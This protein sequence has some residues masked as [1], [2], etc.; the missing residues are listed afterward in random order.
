MLLYCL[1]CRKST[2]RRNPK[3]VRTKSEKIML[4]SKC[5]VCNSKKSKFIRERESSGLLSNLGKKTPLRK[6]SLLGPLLF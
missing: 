5:A 4:L 6:I 2:E 1:K 3:A